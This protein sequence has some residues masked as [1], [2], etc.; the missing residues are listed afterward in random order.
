MTDRAPPSRFTEFAPDRPRRFWTAVDVVA[1]D[2][3][4][5]V[6]LDD[7][8][9]KSPAGSDLFLP[10]EP[11]A[12]LSAEEWAAVGE[13]V[14]PATMPATRLAFTAIDRIPAVRAETADEVAA[15]AGSDA[16]C[17]L[18]EGPSSLVER[19]AREWAPWRDW[20][21]RELGVT[22]VPAEGIVHRAQEPAALARVRELA[23]ALDDFG[24]AAL[25]LA[26]PLLGSAVLALALQR[27][28][29][30]A[31]AAFDLSRLEEDHQERQWGVDAEAAERTAA[32]RAEA[33]LLGRWFRGLA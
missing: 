26:T 18:A 24:L 31:E 21:A 2:A 12:R 11:L 7:R 28:A 15:W 32:R 19:Q 6:T 4:F 25:A 33:V 27:G 22:L 17:Y 10:T 13:L 5:A 1:R 29:L 3:G 23:L 20:A 8:V 16:L 9:P 30:G 14:E